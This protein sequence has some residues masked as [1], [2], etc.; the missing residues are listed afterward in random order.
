MADVGFLRPQKHEI[1]KHQNI[2]R[3]L[4]NIFL[5]G[6]AKPQNYQPPFK[7]FDGDCFTASQRITKGISF[8]EPSFSVLVFL[9]RK[10]L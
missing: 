7:S 2:L 10:P 6:F 5:E 9:W 1:I 8:T 4:Y 3:N